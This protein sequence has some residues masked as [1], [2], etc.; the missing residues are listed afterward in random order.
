MC[1]KGSILIAVLGKKSIVKK[2]YVSGIFSEHQ[3][4]IQLILEFFAPFWP[5]IAL[6]HFTSFAVGIS[7]VKYFL[8]RRFAQICYWSPSGVRRWI[9][10]I[11]RSCFKIT[12]WYQNKQIF[13]VYQETQKGVCLIYVSD[14]WS[15]RPIGLIPQ[16]QPCR[17]R[18]FPRFQ[19]TFS[20]FLKRHVEITILKNV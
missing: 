2:N 18:L 11:A 12:H 17:K 6:C 4:A 7:I 1:D 3:L 13:V 15:F 9:R 10:F 16:M 8:I 5:D 19:K 20:V 14:E